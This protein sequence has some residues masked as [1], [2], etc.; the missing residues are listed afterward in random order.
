MAAGGSPVIANSKETE[1]LID[2]NF[3]SFYHVCACVCICVFHGTILYVRLYV[4]WEMQCT[5]LVILS[6]SPRAGDPRGVCAGRGCSFT[7]P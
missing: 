7:G 6:A 1:F 4:P 2:L 3:C 5:L